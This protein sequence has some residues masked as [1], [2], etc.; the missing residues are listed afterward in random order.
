MYREE[1]DR[2]QTEREQMQQLADKLRHSNDMIEQLLED[3]VRE[4]GEEAAV[5][6]MGR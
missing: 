4:R 5:C 2:L 6:A 1:L 3:K